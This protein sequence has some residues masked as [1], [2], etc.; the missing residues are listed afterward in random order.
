ML[1]LE[2]L[3]LEEIESIEL[4]GE[5][6]TVDIVV[7][8]THMFFANGIYTHNSGYNKEIA[9]E[10]NI[11]K[12][13]EVYQVCD[14]MLMFTQSIPQQEQG[15]CYVQ[16]LK[17]RLGPKGLMLKLKYDPNRVLF[18]ELETVQRSLLYDKQMKETTLQGLDIAR[19][20]LDEIRSKKTG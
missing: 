13:I 4:L 18:M 7:E 12:A 16:V 3:R 2:N 17:N 1:N 19:K 10:Q 9:D 6:P 20:K 5:Q 15:E 11:G 14:F 8:D